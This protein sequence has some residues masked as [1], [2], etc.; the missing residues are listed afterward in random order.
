[1]TTVDPQH[2]V[3]LAPM[4][5]VLTNPIALSGPDGGDPGFVLRPFQGSRTFANL[6]AT[7]RATV[8]VSDDV[9]LFAAAA[10]GRLGDPA[11]LVRLTAD[12][13]WAI[14]LRCHRWFCL[15]IT[16]ITQTPPRFEMQCRV[17]SSGI[18]DPFFGFNRGKH[19]VIEA[20]IL[21][22]RTHL[23]SSDEIQSQLQSLR[24][25]IDK[26]AGE[27]ERRAFDALVDQIN[28]RSQAAA[29]STPPPT[30][31]GESQ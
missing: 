29:P 19:A 30:D 6:Q 26:T 13:N 17:V 2:R 18:Q 5:P 4:G 20:A 23:I 15:Q 31:A 1:M 16:A 28:C 8:H 7:R 22:T 9:E 21:A 27:S 10:I 11:D 3:N 14:M 24:P 12:R 25:L